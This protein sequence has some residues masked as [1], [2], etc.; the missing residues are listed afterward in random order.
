[1]KD[2][3]TF[4]TIVLL[5]F[6]ISRN[7]PA[8]APRYTDHLSNYKVGAFA[9]DLSGNLWIGTS[10]G[11]NRYNGTD[12][13]VF[14][15][16]GQEGWLNNDNISALC[17]DSSGQRLWIGNECGIGY[18]ENGVFQHLN[19]ATFDPVTRILETDPDHI[20]GVGKSGL[21]RFRKN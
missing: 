7:S 4:L 18:L 6:V 2:R 14:N 1:M 5:L 15:A 21:F 10:H 20:I 3:L 19:D 11:L 17:W 12:Y 9:Q 16:S 13:A 8:Q